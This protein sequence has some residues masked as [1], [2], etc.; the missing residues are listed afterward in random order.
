[1]AFFLP[2]GIGGST[3]DALAIAAPLFMS[4]KVWYV[5]DTTG[6][7][8][9]SPEGLDRLAPLATIGQAHTNAADGDIIVCLANH[10]ETIS[11]VMTISKRVTIL[12]E[13][14][15]TF[16]D[17]LRP[18]VTL[19]IGGAANHV[20]AL[21]GVRCQIRNIKFLPRTSAGT[22]SFIQTA[23]AN[24]R[25]TGCR[26]ESNNHSN[27]PGVLLDSGANLV[28][29]ENCTWVATGTS[30]SDRPDSGLR[31]SA[32]LTGLRMDGCVFDGGTTGYETSAGNPWA[33]DCDAGA[34]T[35]YQIEGLSLLRGADLRLH[36]SSVGYCNPQTVSGSS[37]LEV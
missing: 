4:G 29:F 7:D 28:H 13:G 27:A 10:A 20:F 24:H 15:E 16:S 26:F 19:T 36:A 11:S 8:A 1:M 2:N 14:S 32:A 37:R 18:T 9:A 25:I 34:I 22:G 17:G 12:G 33:M 21:T 23:T 3:G 5:K 35:D 6:V 31:A 30:T